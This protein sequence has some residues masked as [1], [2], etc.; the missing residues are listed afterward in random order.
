MTECLMA[1]GLMNCI[2]LSFIDVFVVIAVVVVVVPATMLL[3]SASTVDVIDD[4][5]CIYAKKHVHTKP[6]RLI[7]GTRFRSGITE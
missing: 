7:I 2:F 5:C 6:N 3:E 1:S 4:F